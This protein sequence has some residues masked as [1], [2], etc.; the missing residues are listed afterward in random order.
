VQQRVA[1]GPG[2]NLNRR[3]LAAHVPDAVALDDLCAGARI[4]SLAVAAYL[5]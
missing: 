2:A 5:A 1:A 4:Y 3:L